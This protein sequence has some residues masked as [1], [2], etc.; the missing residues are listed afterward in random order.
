MPREKFPISFPDIY[1]EVQNIKDQIDVRVG[2]GQADAVY[3]F[4]MD[5]L[6]QVYSS[7]AACARSHLPYK[8]TCFQRLTKAMH[9]YLNEYKQLDR[10]AANV[11]RR[12]FDAWMDDI[13]YWLNEKFST[14]PLIKYGKGPIKNDSPRVW[15][16]PFIITVPDYL[17]INSFL[18]P[19]R[20]P[21]STCLI[22]WSFSIDSQVSH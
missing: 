8:Q 6:E 11:L 4:I 18:Y 14:A 2:G 9:H 19:F 20:N 13:S 10:S 7:A 16:K 17:H 1:A 21:N 22:W 5:I 15:C 12:R 3:T